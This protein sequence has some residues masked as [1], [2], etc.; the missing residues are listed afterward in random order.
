MIIIEPHEYLVNRLEDQI[1]WYCN[2]GKLNQKLYKRIG[3]T[4]II[5][6]SLIPLLSGHAGEHFLIPI[7]IGILGSTI[8][9]LESISKLYK[10]HENWI[11]YRETS[12]LLKHE[13]FL[14]LA[15]ITP[16][17]NQNPFQV[18]VERVEMIIS[19][20]NINWSQLHIK[21]SESTSYE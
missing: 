1:N 9:I 6:A 21:N 5:I 8:A 15:Q 17:D 13:K 3:V 19:S 18:L 12:E 16:Y 10:F 4:E 20:E 7:I 2:K 11:K 14:Y